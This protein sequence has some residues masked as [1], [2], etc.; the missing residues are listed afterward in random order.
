MSD[1]RRLNAR[2]ARL[3]NDVAE[4]DRTDA[5]EMPVVVFCLPG[6]LVDDPRL[7]ELVAQARRDGR[8]VV[9][10]EETES[11]ELVDG[12]APARAAPATG[13]AAAR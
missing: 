7:D 13:P 2:V 10:P 11:G 1:P 6:E 5:D 3:A 9:M 4:L 8:F 12:E